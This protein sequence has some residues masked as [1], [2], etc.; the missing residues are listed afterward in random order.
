MSARPPL[1]RPTL[2]MVAKEAGVS[3]AT[4]SR[5][6]NGQ[7]TVNEDMAAVVHAAIERL[8]YV[9]NRAARTLVNRTSNAIA[10]IVPEETTR[11]FQNPFFVAVVEGITARLEQSDFIL[12]LLVASSDPRAK[13]TRFLA[14][15]AVDAA[16]FVA[17][18][19]GDASITDVDR[20]I[21]TVF[22]GR[23]AGEG[24]EG[25]VYI[26][27][28]NADG[29]HRAGQHLIQRGRRRL[30]TIT[31]P[32]DMAAGQ[33]RLN[34]FVRALAEHELEPVGVEVTDFTPRG[35]VRACERLLAR[36]P[37][38]DGLFVA[39]DLMAV[40]ALTWLRSAGR[41]VPADVAV[42][43]FGDDPAASIAEVPLTT[44]RQPSIEMG[45]LLADAA[46]RLIDGDAD[47]APV[48]VLPTELIRR[49]ST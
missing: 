43:G 45:R 13:I 15:G 29:A 28:D 22:A 23:P 49:S 11:F 44:V 9:P 34:G 12:N 17:H 31:G 1:G 7:P 48:T 36:T 38:L 41:D 46:L 8:Q 24:A 10:L 4:V 2:E 26:D 30:A 19:A 20:R 42:V 6:V 3:R 16:I 5:V 33:D 18:H 35:A 32:L 47:V 14:S 39:S 27:T 37:D 21:P 25:R 40:A